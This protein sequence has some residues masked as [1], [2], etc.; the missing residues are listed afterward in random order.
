MHKINFHRVFNDIFT[1]FI[2]TCGIVLMI[3]FFGNVQPKNE[4]IIMEVAGIFFTI[5]ILMFFSEM[6]NHFPNWSHSDGV[7]V[8]SVSRGE[9][10]LIPFVTDSEAATYNAK[11]NA[12]HE[13]GHA[14]MC[15]LSNIETFEV[16]SGHINPRVTYTQK[17]AD[18]EDVK[19]MILIKYAGAA[20]EE[21]L[22]NKFHLGCMF[23]TESDFKDAT[24]LLQSYFIMIDADSGKCMLEQ[25][26]AEQMIDLSKELYKNAVGILKENKEKLVILSDEL[27]KKN[28]MTKDEIVK[29][30][31]KRNI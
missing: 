2:K 3:N 30:L 31:E 21:I 7:V 26:Y 18:A 12:I 19:K 8:E 9:A 1:C 10:V 22:M 14:L 4:I 15:Y 25:V 6:A 24:E 16:H 23:G 29:L 27:I 28:T 11:V 17:A 5:I 20:A 13:A